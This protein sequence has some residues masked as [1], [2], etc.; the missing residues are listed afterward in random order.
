[1]SLPTAHHSRPVLSWETLDW[2]FLDRLRQRFL[3]GG[4]TDH[5]YW[6]SW[7]DL[8][9]Y[10]FTY[11]RRIGWK[12][13]AVLR[14]L[15][16][17]GWQPPA[18]PVLDW[19][20]GSGVAGRRVVEGF[21]AEH[22]GT[23]GVHDRSPLAVAFA[24][25]AAREAFPAL[26]VEPVPD[27]ANFPFTMLLISHV[28]NEL[29]IAGREVLR[30]LLARAQAVLWVEP[31]TY[32]DSRGLIDFREELLAGGFDAVAPC[33][34]RVRCGMRNAHNAPHWCHHFAE[35]PPT[36]LADGQWTSFARR[37]GIDLR[38][39]PYSFLVL[40][41]RDHPPDDAGGWTRVI[42]RPRVYKGHAKVLDCSREDVT[43][44]ALQE[45][46]N[47]ELFRGFKKGRCPTLLRTSD[48]VKGW[49]MVEETA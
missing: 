31:G 36:V 19:G 3:E 23:L 29:D 24:V 38:A 46:D 44:I 34:H 16:L 20:C 45:R 43:D 47:R 1:M 37:A 2:P 40:E 13:D 49:K 17:R 42:G 35:T 12:W 15:K 8:A 22:F 41:R 32:Q 33:T 48:T 7:S 26:T 39:V 27:A 25:G 14:E 18:G 11:A 28:L 9:N 30:A 4:K 10:D 6:D 21:G 5:A